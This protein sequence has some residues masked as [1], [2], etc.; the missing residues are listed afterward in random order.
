[1]FLPSV[2]DLVKGNKMAH[3]HRVDLEGNLWYAVDSFEFPITPT[4]WKGGE[5]KRDEKAIHLMRWIRKHLDYLKS[6][7]ETQGVLTQEED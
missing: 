1:M 3:F 2:G 7:M 5:F 6:A 4:E